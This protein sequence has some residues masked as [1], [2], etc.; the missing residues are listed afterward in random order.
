[1]NFLILING[2]PKYKYFFAE[3]AKKIEEKGHYVYF[4]I[5]AKKSSILEPLEYI[6]K[7]DNSF[8]FDE[9]ISNNLEKIRLRK[10][11]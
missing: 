10:M 6:D 8:F 9:Y 4:A 7:S 11:I 2:A 5:N 3:I 1:M